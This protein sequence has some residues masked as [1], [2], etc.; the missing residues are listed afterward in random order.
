[1]A[2]FTQ[3]DIK[4]GSA[5]MLSAH[6]ETE[7]SFDRAPAW[8]TEWKEIKQHFLAT[9][10]LQGQSFHFCCSAE[11]QWEYLFQWKH[12][13]VIYLSKEQAS[14]IIV[15]GIF[16]Y[17]YSGLMCDHYNFPS[18]GSCCREMVIHNACILH[19]LSVRRWGGWRLV[20][21]KSGEG[22]GSNCWCRSH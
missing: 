20:R 3:R 4:G 16:Y 14:K 5:V 18:R 19:Y 22:E 15:H 13:R 17:G 6:T 9:L 7:Q 8:S 1:M 2:F 12:I 11:H 10:Q 21:L